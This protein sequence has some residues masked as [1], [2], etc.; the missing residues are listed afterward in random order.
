MGESALKRHAAGA[1]HKD[2]IKLLENDPK[3]YEFIKQG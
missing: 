2:L 1:K 3:I